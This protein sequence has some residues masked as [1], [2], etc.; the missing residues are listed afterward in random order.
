MKI[1]L[2]RL[3]IVSSVVWSGL[4]FSTP[5]MAAEDIVISDDSLHIRTLA[6]SCAACHGTQGNAVGNNQSTETLTLAGL[7]REH[8][9]QRLMDFRTGA[10][11][12]TV[13]HHHAKGLT[14]DEI[15]QLADYFSHQPVVKR[16]A[17]QAQSLKAVAK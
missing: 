9:A 17:P 13:M 4:V 1:S 3:V 12:S 5:G 10:R 15:N 7:G 16:Y 14:V 8:I 2:I 6:A 11:T